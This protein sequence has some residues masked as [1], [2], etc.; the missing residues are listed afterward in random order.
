M[1]EQRGDRIHIRDL[2]LRCIV[3]VFSEERREKQDVTI[4]ITL[5]AD[6]RPSGRSD[7]L[8]DTVDYKAIKQQV[9]AMVEQSSFQ[10]VER[11]AQAIADICLAPPLVQ[12]VQVTVEKPGAL[13]FARTVSVEI[14][15]RRNEG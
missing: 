8:A 10:L 12:A 15:R 2:K 14:T 4:Q 3:G 7:N 1:A 6:L 11:L 9:V 13:R 5:F